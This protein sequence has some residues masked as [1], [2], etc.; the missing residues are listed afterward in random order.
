MLGVSIGFPLMQVSV[1]AGLGALLRENPP[2]LTAMRGLGAAYL[3]YLAWRIATARPELEP[4]DPAGKPQPS[5][6]RPMSFLQAA[7]FQWVNP[8]A[9]LVTISAL[10]TVASVGG[11]PSTPRALTLAAVFLFVTL[12]ITAFW[13]I[14]GVGVSRVFTTERALRRFN[15]ALAALLVASLVSV[16]VGLD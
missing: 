10:A 16:L 13:T 8:K 12:P 11:H 5:S 15:L 6:R 7:L 2:V 4:A 9:W 14:V 1:A 3:L